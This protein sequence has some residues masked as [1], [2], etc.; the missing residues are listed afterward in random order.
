MLKVESIDN[1]GDNEVPYGFVYFSDNARVVYAYTPGGETH[2][3]HKES[4]GWGPVTD[5]H[6]RLANKALAER[7]PTKFGR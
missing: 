4:G 7:Y 1:R 6:V 2:G 3:A 5:T